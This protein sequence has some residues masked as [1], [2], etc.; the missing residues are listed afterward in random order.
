MEVAVAPWTARAF[1]F[2][3]VPAHG[4]RKSARSPAAG[5]VARFN[6]DH[7]VVEDPSGRV[8]ALVV[9]FSYQK[10]GLTKGQ[11]SSWNAS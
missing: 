1:P 6:V 4:A 8:F 10:V 2:V 9:Y 3:D 5:A 11:L 7:L